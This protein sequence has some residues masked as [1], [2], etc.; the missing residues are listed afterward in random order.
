M[1]YRLIL[2]VERAS[3]YH[4]QNRPVAILPTGPFQSRS[5]RH[6]IEETWLPLFLLVS[7][8]LPV[9]HRAPHQFLL[10]FSLWLLTIRSLEKSFETSI[11]V[12]LFL[13]LAYSQSV[14]D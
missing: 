12:Y 6:L 8:V 1:L 3:K 5:L 14:R 10:I 4:A 13:S 9:A 2:P 7:L 11:A